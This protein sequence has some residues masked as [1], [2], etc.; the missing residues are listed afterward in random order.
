MRLE[1]DIDSEVYPELH[2]ALSALKSTRAR[3][4]RLR[5]LA[6]TG[7]V[8]EKV[9][10]HGSAAMAAPAVDAPAEIVTRADVKPLPPQEPALRP[11]DRRRKRPSR[12]DVEQVMRELPVLMDVVA[13]VRPLPMPHDDEPQ[14]TD[15]HDE[16]A[17]W[18]AMNA[19]P[20]D[21]STD[22]DAPDGTALPDAALHVTA[23]SHK[24]ATR[25][26]LMRMKERGLFKN[27]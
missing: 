18:A 7:L 2:A 3:A 15:P 10:L 5:Q 12:E 25:S 16:P 11:P 17:P 26:R 27:G 23:L 22:D 19:Y 24:P 21:L 9:R 6:A 1:I 4:E 13:D 14:H 20:D 8:G